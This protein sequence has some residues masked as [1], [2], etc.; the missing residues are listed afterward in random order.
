MP[1]FTPEELK[2]IQG[3]ILSGYAH[4]RYG[5]YLFLQVKNP[6]QARAWL[7]KV[8]PLIT[9]SERWEVSPTGD[10]KKPNV[11]TN[12]GFTHSG[13]KALRLPDEALLSFARE[14]IWGMGERSHTLGD[15]GPSAPENWEVGGPNT[16]EVHAVLYLNAMDEETL[17]HWRREHRKLLEE[18]AGGVV[19]V[20]EQH[21]N[22]PPSEKEH[23][24]FH[25]GIAQPKI[26][27]M[28]GCP[29]DGPNVVA[30]GEI[31][32]GYE[33]EFPGGMKPPTPWMSPDHDPG[34]LLQSFGPE[35][36]ALQG[37]RNFG[38]R[39]TYMVYRKL[40]QDVA[41]F[42]D[43]MAANARRG[44]DGSPDV[45]DM[46]YLAAK[47]VGR[48]PSGAPL[49]LAPDHDDPE[50][51]RDD[52]RNDKFLYFEKDRDGYAC[53]LGSHIRRCNPRDSRYLE[54][55]RKF[56]LGSSDKHRIIRRAVSFGPDL[57]PRDEVE[58][59]KI[60]ANLKD[61]GQERGLHFF[62]LNANLRSQFEFLQQVWCDNE[63]FEG[64]DDNKDPLIGDNDGT[65]EMVIPNHP[66]RRRLSHLPRFITPK[67]GAYF[68]VPSLTSLRYL[69]SQD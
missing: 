34:N 41:G 5:A 59:G 17:D 4:L 62:G 58:L 31:I 32:L 46:L 66:V 51:G 26:Q 48:W 23:F 54:E 42:W 53:P 13:F 50:L 35:D 69:A 19:E 55:D 39:G 44:P 3:I 43:Y 6:T 60:P 14:F 21:G 7:K 52:N 63:V 68:F 24:G 56:A 22:R 12:L 1:E 38:L 8:I 33:N 27:R 30:T 18:N 49:V 61:D 20:N 15:R 28:L 37:R 40:A 25:D 16:P 11:T 65:G 10:K 29:D 67:G 64:L 45:Q 2:D 9:T 47:C 57:F 36:T